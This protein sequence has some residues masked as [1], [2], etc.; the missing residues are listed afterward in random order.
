M[1]RKTKYSILSAAAGL[2]LLGGV[3]AAGAADGN[4]LTNGDF[5]FGNDGWLNGPT[6][7]WVASSGGIEGTLEVTNN[8]PWDLKTLALVGQCVPVE[9]GK[10][11]TLSAKAF[12]PGGQEREGG[13]QALMVF[14]TGDACN[15]SA[16]TNWE[17]GTVAWEDNWGNLSLTHVAP[18]GANSA[19]AYL[20]ATKN[21]PY[22]GDDWEA[23]LRVHFDNVWFGVAEADGGERPEDDGGEP[24]VL[25]EPENPQPPDEPQVEG[26]PGEPEDEPADEPAL[27]GDP[28]AGP[29]DE[30]EVEEEPGDEPKDEPGDEPQGEP[31]DEPQDEP[32]DEPQELDEP[33]EYVTSPLPPDTG[34]GFGTDSPEL[35]LAAGVIGAAMATA[36][37]GAMLMPA[38]RRR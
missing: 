11:Y 14:D 12:L 3:A 37:G 33:G 22:V 28:D 13:G 9:A 17:T 20:S 26:E 25:E 2:S 21:K 34:T 7:P 24:V 32:G 23:P 1:I 35:M 18:A 31:G 30:P 16:L 15:G 36:L 8:A 4:L 6:T 38:R 5:D 10:E 29:P 27:E 19:W